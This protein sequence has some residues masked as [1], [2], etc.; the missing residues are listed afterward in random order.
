MKMKVISIII[1]VTMLI[2]CNESKSPLEIHPWNNIPI[3]Q[4]DTIAT[5][6]LEK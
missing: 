6:A 5:I 1:S 2:G 4:A 3:E